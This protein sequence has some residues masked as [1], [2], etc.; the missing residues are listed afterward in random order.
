MSIQTLTLAPTNNTDAN[1]RLWGSGISTALAAAGLV[2]TSDTGQI[3][4]TT[5]V[6]PTTSTQSRG[7]E[8]WRFAD[9]LQSTRPVFVRLDYGS[10]AVTNTPGVYVSTGTATDGAGLLTSASTLPNTTLWS[11]GNPAAPFSISTTGVVFYGAGNDYSTAT[12]NNL[13]V[14]SD[15]SSLLLAGWYN[16]AGSSYPAQSGGLLVVERTRD[17]DGAANGDGVILIKTYAGA[18]PTTA[19]TTLGRAYSFYGATAAGAPV[20]HGGKQASVPASGVVGATLNTFPV[21]TGALPQLSGPSKH[22]VAV[23]SA[24]QS[25][26]TQFDVT[27]YSTTCTYRSLGTHSYGWSNEGGSAAVTGAFRVA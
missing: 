1:F 5:V 23:W 9:S 6:K 13:Y 10:S 16:A 8:M 15:T 17:Q 12:L 22:L 21:F 25:V 20:L 19:I 14:A 11:P 2:Q 18:G 26:N 7:Y 24:D 3:N 4:W 27:V